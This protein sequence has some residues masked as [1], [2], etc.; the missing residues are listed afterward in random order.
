[1]RKRRKGSN[2]LPHK[3]KY[4]SLASKSHRLNELIHWYG[5]FWNIHILQ[6]YEVCFRRP[7]TIS[8]TKKSPRSNGYKSHIRWEQGMYRV[9]WQDALR[10]N[11][12]LKDFHALLQVCH[13]GCHRLKLA[14][15]G[16]ICVCSRVSQ[17]CMW[18]REI[19]DRRFF[20]VLIARR[21]IASKWETERVKRGFYNTFGSCPRY[22]QAK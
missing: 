4:H 15:R 2:H 21:W 13:N 1:M 18:E 5:N 14:A 6:P 10:T 7:S 3:S 11:L 12:L 8:Y 16:T 17:S 22:F 9:S 20:K 19:S